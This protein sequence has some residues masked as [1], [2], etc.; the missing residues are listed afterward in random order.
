MSHEDAQE[1][2]GAYAVDAVDTDE[3]VRIEAHVADCPRCGAELAAHRDTAAVLG[4]GHVEP[5]ADLWDRVAASLDEVPPPLDLTRYAGARRRR[6][7]VPLVAAA[8]ALV[9]VIGLSVVTVQQR[10][11]INRIEATVRGA[12]VMPQALAAFASPL[13]KVATMKA[14][15]VFMRA[16]VYPNGAGYLIVDEIPPLPA[17]RT[18]QLWA[19]GAAEP[20]SAGVLGRAPGIVAFQTSES[21]PALAI[22]VEP[23]GGSVRPSLPPLVQGTLEA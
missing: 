1:L 9:A 2:L 23:A 22:T 19:V 17:G 3:A 12:Y 8:A 10:R 11:D 21:T 14:D 4:H 16:A 15:G 13:T 20:I 6:I 5:P 7:A 18:Y